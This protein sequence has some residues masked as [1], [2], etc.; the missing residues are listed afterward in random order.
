MNY[1]HYDGDNFVATVELLRK[2]FLLSYAVKTEFFF[3]F[4]QVYYKQ[5]G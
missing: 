4:E 3:N 5:H 2:K 1:F